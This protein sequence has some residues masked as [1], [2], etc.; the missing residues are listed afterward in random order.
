MTLVCELEQATVEYVGEERREA[1]LKRDFEAPRA[2]AALA[3]DRSGMQNRAGLHR[4][5]AH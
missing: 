3:R 2:K 4:R 5:S 1:S